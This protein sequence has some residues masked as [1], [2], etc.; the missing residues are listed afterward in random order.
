MKRAV[1]FWID[2][3]HRFIV[4]LNIKLG[5]MREGG[6]WRAVECQYCMRESLVYRSCYPCAVHNLHSVQLLTS[7]LKTASSIQNMKGFIFFMY[8]NYYESVEYDH[9]Y[10][11]HFLS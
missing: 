8:L 9:Y 11:H 10:Y 3:G 1:T 2:T 4:G 6:E 7:V 5:T